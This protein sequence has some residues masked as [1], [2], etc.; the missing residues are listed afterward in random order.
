MKYL[1]AQL[2]GKPIL[3]FY[4]AGH[5]TKTLT[6]PHLKEED[7][8]WGQR[9]NEAGTAVYT[10]YVLGVSG[11]GFWRGK[12]VQYPASLGEFQFDDGTFL[13][14][15][16]ESHPG[17]GILYADLRTEENRAIKLP[18][19][20]QDIPASQVFDGLLIFKQFTPMENACQTP[21]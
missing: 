13:P 17:T 19:D 1:V 6:A 15:L 3:A 12:S 16:F 2:G 8:S 20:N 9:L 11:N 10:L 5:G 4:G 18:P 14:S 7:K 21:E